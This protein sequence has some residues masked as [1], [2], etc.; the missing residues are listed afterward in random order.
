IQSS[1]MSL[2]YT[3]PLNE[4][5]R[6]CKKNIHKHEEGGDFKKARQEPEL[7]LP[8]RPINLHLLL[9]L[10]ICSG[11]LAPSSR[12]SATHEDL[13]P[14]IF[15]PALRKPS[16]KSFVLK[17]TASGRGRLLKRGSF[18]AVKTE[19]LGGLERLAL[20]L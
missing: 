14:S 6:I 15:P 9:L 13:L 16:V 4:T 2:S 18:P 8:S 12:S 11:S 5:Q 17:L 3:S 1:T 10:A 19:G 7:L 20:S